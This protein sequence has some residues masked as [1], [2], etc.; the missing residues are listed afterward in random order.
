[1]LWKSSRKSSKLARWTILRDDSIKKIEKKLVTIVGETSNFSLQIMAHSKYGRSYF[2]DFSSLFWD[3]ISILYFWP[4]DSSNLQYYY[5]NFKSQIFQWQQHPF[6]SYRFVP[7]RPFYKTCV[8]RRNSQLN[9][10]FVWNLYRKARY[11]RQSL[12]PESIWFSQNF[13]TLLFSKTR[14]W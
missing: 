3:I 5:L 9:H 10:K 2:P 6:S 8:S 11:W 7:S 13:S 1:M 14:L 12:F 4:N